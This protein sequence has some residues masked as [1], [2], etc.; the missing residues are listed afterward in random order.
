MMMFVLMFCVGCMSS[1]TKIDMGKTD[2]RDV[3]QKIFDEMDE[4]FDAFSK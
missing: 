2:K 4:M 3:H 1:I